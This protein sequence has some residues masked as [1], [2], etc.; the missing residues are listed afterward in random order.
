MKHLGIFIFVLFFFNQSLQAQL[1]VRE[2]DKKTGKVLLRG[3]MQFSDIQKESTCVWFVKGADAYQPDNEAIQTLKKVSGDYRYIVFIGTWCED[4]R[5]LFPKFYKVLQ[6]ARIDEH[7]V[8][9]YGVN[10]KK[11]A[12]NIE[13]TL[14]N[15]QK[16]PTIIVMHQFREVG[17]IVESSTNIETELA[18]LMEKDY[19]RLEEERAKKF[20]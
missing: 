12:L 7:A 20:K 13:H 3:L 14:Y 2:E 19:V 18:M 17:R 9:L 16:V 4:T 1:M 15:I 10:R 11:E 6:D 5:N 8:E